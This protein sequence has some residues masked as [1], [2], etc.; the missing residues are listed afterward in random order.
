MGIKKQ[1]DNI[2]DIS[3]LNDH[4]LLITLIGEIRLLKVE[5]TAM[6]D[7]T[8]MRVLDHESRIRRL[9]LWGGI[10]IGASYALQFY[11]Q[12]LAR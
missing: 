2:I 5:V 7:D 10:L 9:E 4:D 6:K 12:F 8:K 1:M 3:K 11:F